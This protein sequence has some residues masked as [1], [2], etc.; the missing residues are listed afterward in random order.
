MFSDE[1]LRWNAVNGRC[2]ALCIYGR[3]CGRGLRITTD[4][5]FSPW[6][7]RIFYGDLPARTSFKLNSDLTGRVLPAQKYP[8]RG[9][10]VAFRNE[11]K[12]E[13]E[14]EKEEE[15]E[16]DEEKEV[17]EEA[18][19]SGIDPL[20]RNFLRDENQRERST[21]RVSQF[22]LANAFCIFLR[23]SLFLI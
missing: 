20:R 6:I 2:G 9:T 16:E 22:P 12:E 4:K 5:V 10:G 7:F 18:T 17:K 21:R 13:E 15:E 14:E 3:P 11:Q 8:L 19:G 1:R 23:L